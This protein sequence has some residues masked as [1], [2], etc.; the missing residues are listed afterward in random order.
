M[1]QGKAIV[2]TPVGCEGLDVVDGQHLLVAA[3]PHAFASA[4]VRLLADPALRARLGASARRLAVERYDWGT[5]AGE[6]EQFYEELA[7]R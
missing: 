4:I 6:L 3:T 7:C 5:I 2:S 1:A